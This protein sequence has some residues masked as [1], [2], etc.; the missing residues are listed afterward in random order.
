MTKD[1]DGKHAAG[2]IVDTTRANESS[3]QI[4]KDNEKRRKEEKSGHDK[5][6][7]S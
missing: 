7:Q 5:Q 4:E 3:E 6:D 1:R 2:S